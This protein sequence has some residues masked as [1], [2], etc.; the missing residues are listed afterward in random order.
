MRAYCGLNADIKLGPKSA[1]KRHRNLG[2][3]E[4]NQVGLAANRA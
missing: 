4:A 3:I 1:M 2:I